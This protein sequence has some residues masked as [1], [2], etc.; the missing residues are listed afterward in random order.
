[1]PN[2]M[3][4]KPTL[5]VTVIKAP[6]CRKSVQ[7]ATCTDPAFTATC[8]HW[9][10]PSHSCSPIVAPSA[11]R[12]CH[13]ARLYSTSSSSSSSISTTTII[14]TVTLRRL[15]RV[16]TYPGSTINTR[17]TMLLLLITIIVRQML[18][19]V[20]KGRVRLR[21]LPVTTLIASPNSPNRSLTG[22]NLAGRNSNRKIAKV[23]KI[24]RTQKSSPP[25]PP[26]PMR[27]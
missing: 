4:P 22:S 14:I 23:V 20:I 15:W 12:I 24:T 3:R 25:R 17:L 18:T 5:S 11:S 8:K 2:T 10:L 27:Y 21:V 13:L 26:L 19:R 1:M 9:L 16:Q 7:I 6:S